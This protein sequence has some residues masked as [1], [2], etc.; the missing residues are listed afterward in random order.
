MKK[1]ISIILFKIFLYPL[2][3]FNIMFL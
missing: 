1:I 2:R 3:I